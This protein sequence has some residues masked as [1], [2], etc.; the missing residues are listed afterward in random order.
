MEQA[1][2]FE[3]LKYFYCEADFGPAD[4]DVRKGIQER[5]IRDTKK[6]LPKGY[7]IEE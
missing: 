5:F 3:F 1:T 4:G 7:E 6:L 2:E